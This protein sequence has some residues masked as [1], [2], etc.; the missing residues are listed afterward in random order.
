MKYNKSKLGLLKICKINSS[1]YNL[2]YP[3]FS[4]KDK[5]QR[6]ILLSCLKALT[7]K[8]PK[9]KTMSSKLTDMLWP[10]SGR[11]II[12]FSNVTKFL[13]ATMRFSYSKKNIFHNLVSVIFMLF[14]CYMYIINNF[15][16]IFNLYVIHVLAYLLSK[17]MYCRE[18]GT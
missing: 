5:T 10:L 2:A 1:K 17:I 3:N 14:T 8:Y 9:T 6:Y 11:G 18:Y 16:K 15:R 4:G 12:I 13:H 7:K